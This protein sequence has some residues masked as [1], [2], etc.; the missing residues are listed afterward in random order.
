MISRATLID[1]IVALLQDIP[2]LV[3]AMGDE[4]R[5]RPFHRSFPDNANVERAIAAMGSPAILVVWRATQQAGVG[6]WVHEFSLVV[7]SDSDDLVPLIIDGVPVSD[8][9]NLKMILHDVGDTYGMAQ[10]V[11]VQ[12]RTLFAANDA[13]ID[14][15]D[16]LLR[17]LEKR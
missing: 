11:F 5:I 6:P 15:D 16:I 7:R 3:A 4:D 2:P 14:Y 9:K 12:P 8:G 13:V 17:L 1:Q 10:A